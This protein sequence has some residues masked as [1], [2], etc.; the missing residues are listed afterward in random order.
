MRNS[1]IKNET[2][3]VPQNNKPKEAI[4]PIYLLEIVPQEQRN[5]SPLYS[6]GS[7]VGGSSKE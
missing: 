6:T 3:V 7:S 2:R 1:F 4:G 5:F